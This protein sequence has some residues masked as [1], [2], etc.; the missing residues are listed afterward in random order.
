M[1]SYPHRTTLPPESP[2]FGTRYQ[3][4]KKLGAGGMGAVFQANDTTLD[5]LVAV[6]ILLPG[7]SQ[8]NIIRFQQEA[9]TAAKLDHPN[10]VKVL[11]FGQ[12][13]TGDL[14]L[15]MDYVGS[16]SLEDLQRR[17]RQLPLDEAL[18]I[19]IQIAAGLHHAHVNKVLHRDVKPSNI[20]LCEKTPGNVQLVDFGL[21]KLK[22]EDQR[23]TSTGVRVGSPLYMS[24]EQARGA[25]VGEASDLYSFGCLM[26]KILTGK[27]PLQGDTYMDTIM[28][29]ME[30]EAPLLNEIDCGTTF[31]DD[32]EHVIA[33]TLEKD[34][35]DRY[36]SALQLKERLE[37][38]YENY[39]EQ[40]QAVSLF[41]ETIPSN[42]P[43]RVE[44]RAPNAL[45]DAKDFVLK[46]RNLSLAL[47]L[48]I[49]A[50]PVW[51]F[52]Y[53]LVSSSEKKTI[54]VV[55]DDGISRLGVGQAFPSESDLRK[56]FQE[57][58]VAPRRQLT[59]TERKIIL[60]QA[61]QDE[62]PEVR[63]MGSDPDLQ[64]A[65]L[66]NRQGPMS[67]DPG[68]REFFMSPEFQELQ[69]VMSQFW[70][71]PALKAVWAD[72]LS[73]EFMR[74]PELWKLWKTKPKSPKIAKFVKNSN[75]QI[76]A[77]DRRFIS[78]SNDPKFEKLIRNPH[79]QRV[80][81]DPTNMKMFRAMSNMREV[82]GRGFA[83]MLE[84]LDPGD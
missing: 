80:L 71:D 66:A 76:L 60:R 77:K 81:K 42:A 3:I 4:L 8:E 2:E 10:I 74:T 37:Q 27:P 7:L 54:A 50:M 70:N 51:I 53:H 20:M 56:R 78:L 44:H 69:P 38:V 36:E 6:K 45:L 17:S 72:P 35:N 73:Q 41:P 11:D 5:K 1:N 9:R 19:F 48:V 13:P 28:M 26:F 40:M 14:F 68:A 21:A 31:P 49:L 75:V 47:G 52:S 79:F 57:T 34:P 84:G 12:T 46:H 63:Q 55:E 15:V 64:K 39:M 23:L 32:L 82:V 18:P 58:R 25:D 59:E 43:V 16:Q 83:N 62:D 61:A 29:Q 33:K 65:F 22:T 30:V 24:P 67:A